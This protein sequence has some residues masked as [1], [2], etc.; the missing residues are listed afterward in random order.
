MAGA[1]QTLLLTLALWW[2][3]MYATWT[4]NYLD[5]DHPAMRLTMAGMMLAGL[6]MATALSQAF[7]ARALWFAAA[8]VTIQVGGGG[9]GR[10]AARNEPIG[11]T[12]RLIL[13]WHVVSAALWI[14]GA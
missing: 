3:W 5:P 12:F 1:A 14:G 9:G 8:Y 4:T 6:A 10:G 2:A 7:G 13:A 11:H